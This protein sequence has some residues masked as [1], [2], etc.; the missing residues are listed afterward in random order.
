MTDLQIWFLLAF[1][2]SFA[3]AAWWIPR[4]FVPKANGII[5]NMYYSLGYL[6]FWFVTL[7]ITWFSLD[8]NPETYK[9]ILLSLLNWFIVVFWVYAFTK[10]IDLMWISV[11]NALKNTQ[12]VFA[13]IFWIIFLWELSNYNWL[14]IA[15]WAILLSLVWIILSKSSFKEFRVHWKYLLLPIISWI[16]FTFSIMLLKMAENIWIWWIL[17]FMWLAEFISFYTIAKIK[18]IKTITKFEKS[19]WFLAGI[20]IS[21][22]L[23]LVW[24]TLKYIEYWIWGSIINLNTVWLILISLIFFKELD[25]KNYKKEIIISIILSFLAMYLFY[26]WKN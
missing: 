19:M 16:A 4:K 6:V 20:L 2:S 12:P 8:L 14:Y 1:I 9:S 26:L 23:V 21:I 18:K 22:A 17:I 13:V 11:S 24:I 5:Y 10:S 25:W 15:W 3:M 7:C